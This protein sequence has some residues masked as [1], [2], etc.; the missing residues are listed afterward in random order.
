MTSSQGTVAIVL[1]AGK[2]TRMRSAQP[3]VLFPL[4]GRT[5]VSRVLDA[6]GQAGCEQ[7]VV[8]V[9]H[10]KEQV[11][12]EL[13]S[14]PKYAV[15]QGMQGTGQA[16]AAARGVLNFAEQTVLILP[17][18]VPLITTESLRRLLDQHSTSGAVLTVATMEPADSH[19]YGR[20]LRSEDQTR[21]LRIVE[22]RDCSPVELEISEVNTSIYAASGSFL[23][24]TDGRSGALAQLN[25][26]ND[27]GEYLL[28]DIV[29]MAADQ[30]L[31]VDAFV[32]SD[33]SEV[34]G[35]NDRSQL[36]ALEAEL[37]GRILQD[38]LT[39]GVSLERP[40]NT[41]VEEAVKLGRDVALGAGVELRGQ[42]AIA[43]GVSIGS[44]CILTDVTVG[45]G[46]RLAP[47]VVAEAVDIEA[48]AWVKPFSVLSGRN[49][50]KPAESVVEDRVRVGSSA[51]VG[52]FT[53]LRQASQ[54][55]EGAKAGNFVEMKKTQLGEGAKANHL[56]YLGDAQIGAKS[57][58]GAGVITCNYDGFA[59]HQTIIREGVFVG[60][61]SYLVA[62]IRLGKGSYVATGTTVTRD[63]PADA[64]AIGRIRQ[65]NKAGYASRLRDRL[66]YLSEK[67]KAKTAATNSDPEN[68]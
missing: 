44:G 23:F 27:Q 42:T 57:N 31:R 26:D 11:M 41:R 46:A 4:L 33:P 53:H 39:A 8:V 34:A 2:G 56:T 5:L 13:G 61:G 21:V 64:L 17:G 30:G 49:E 48:G 25:T 59:K 40:D 15:Q 47:Y 52:P 32:L 67:A 19:G 29:S 3:K 7:Q 55:G 51:Q 68:S 65:E 22:H 10:C 58:I 62:P 66:E 9:G 12:T 6:A 16:V 37:Q 38:W 45:E 20:V 36:A 24:G 43:D 35:I 63:V 50:K 14:S 1:A 60:T 18:D 54:L 28:T